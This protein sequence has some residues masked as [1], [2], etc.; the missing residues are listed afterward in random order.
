MQLKSGLDQDHGTLDKFQNSVS[1]L[2]VPGYM[3]FMLEKIRS[4]WNQ[5]HWLA[6]KSWN[7]S[8]TST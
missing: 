8:G 1:S 5:E 6:L 7:C 4:V 2:G 3:P